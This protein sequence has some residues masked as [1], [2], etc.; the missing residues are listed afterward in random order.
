[1]NLSWLA[2]IRPDIVFEISHT[3]QV[4]RARVKIDTDKNFTCINKAIKYAHDHQEFISVPK[5]DHNTLRITAYN[6]A[7]FA[8]NANQSSQ[9]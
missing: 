3:A 5:L 4:T 9:L 7:A 8:N 1:M 2:N 6:D